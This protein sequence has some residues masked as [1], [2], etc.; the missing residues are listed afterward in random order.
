MPGLA[1]DVTHAPAADSAEALREAILEKLRSRQWRAGQRLPTERVLGEQYGLSRST[2][3]RVLGDFKRRRLITQ[4]VGSGTYVADQVHQALAEMAS[5]GPL[6]ATSPSELMAA[7]LV[8]EPAIVD[9]VIGNATA[10]DYQRMDGCNAH[11]EAATTL[12]AFE[13]WDAQLH[14]AIADAAHNSFVAA[15]FRLMNEVRAQGE[16]GVLKRRSA[17]P[18]RRLEYQQEHRA[19]VDALKQ[20]DAERARALCLAHLLHVRTNMLGP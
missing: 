19:L 14:E 3:R 20:R 10:H 17:T 1:T 12:E 7:R 11:A 8:L 15:V 5:A 6:Q 13:H 4:T 2:V 18:E 9:M 16:W